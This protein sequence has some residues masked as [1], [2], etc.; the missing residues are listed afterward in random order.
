MKDNI[1]HLDKLKM[2]RDPVKNVCDAAAKE[3]TDLIII[4]EDK[5]GKIQ[6]ITTVPEPADLIWF[7]KVCEHGIMSKGVEEDE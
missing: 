6:M 7:L 1:I 4:G 3:F 5:H 2:S